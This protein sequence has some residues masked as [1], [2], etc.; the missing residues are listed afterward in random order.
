MG[1]RIQASHREGFLSPLSS[2]G[3]PSAQNSAQRI[4]GT[5][6]FVKWS[7]DSILRI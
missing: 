7:D 3:S 6:T 1:T 5:Q 4:E 2:T